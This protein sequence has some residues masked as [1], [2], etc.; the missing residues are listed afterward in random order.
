MK[1]VSIAT[2]F[3]PEWSLP[4]VL[5]FGIAAW[6]LGARA[7]GVAAVLLVAAEFVLPP[8]L[9][10]WLTT[11]PDWAILLIGGVLLLVVLHDVVDFLFGKETA[12][13]VTGT[14]LVRLLDALLLSPFR[15]LGRLLGWRRPGA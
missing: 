3:L 1:G 7:T 6:I 12:G 10:P 2:L 13:H 14:F 4:W 5:L 9:E 15:L 8:L 11:L